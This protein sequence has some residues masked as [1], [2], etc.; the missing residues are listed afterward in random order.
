MK[1]FYILVLVGV[2]S[3]VVSVKTVNLKCLNPFQMVEMEAQR[4]LSDLLN[5][6]ILIFKIY[7]GSA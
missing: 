5:F 4:N 3:Y 2:T 6:E 1:M 7:F